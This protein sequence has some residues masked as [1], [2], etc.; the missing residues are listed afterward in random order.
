MNNIIDVIIPTY[1]PNRDFVDI[2]EKLQNQTIKPN[3][4]IGVIVIIKNVLNWFLL[5]SSPTCL[6]NKIQ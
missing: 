2:I 1:K 6:N 5:F 3:K 4:I